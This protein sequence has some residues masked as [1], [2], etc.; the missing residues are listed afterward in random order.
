MVVIVHTTDPGPQA[1]D[2]CQSV[3]PV[4]DQATQEVSGGHHL[5]SVSCVCPIP[6]HPH[7]WKNCLPQNWS[8]VPRRLGTTDLY[9][10]CEFSTVAPEEN[11]K[12][13][14]CGP[15]ATFSS[16]LLICAYLGMPHLVCVVDLMASNS[17]PTTA[18]GHAEESHLMYFSYCP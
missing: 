15:L 12:L 2:S 16:A 1:T 7:P 11:T 4:R 10:H 3:W 9:S 13:G 17:W 6:L 14:W 8:L 5:S 18:L